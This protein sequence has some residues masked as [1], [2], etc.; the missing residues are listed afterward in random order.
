MGRG[1]MEERQAR[2]LSVYWAFDQVEMS[3]V[4]SEQANEK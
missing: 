3:D 4:Q 2:V 1:E